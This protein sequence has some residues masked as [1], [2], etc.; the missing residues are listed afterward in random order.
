MSK[1]YK[2][3]IIGGGL[4][5]C[6][7][8]YSL[9]KRGINNIALIDEN[10]INQQDLVGIR[11]IIYPRLEADWN[12]ITKFYFSALE[13]FMQFMKS[14]A[15]LSV[16]HDFCGLVQFPTLKRN[17]F[18]KLIKILNQS[19]Q[20]IKLIAGEQIGFANDNLLLFPNLGWVSP[21]DLCKAYLSNSSAD[22]YEDEK[23]IDIRKEKNGLWSLI[24]ENSNFYAETIIIANSYKA[25]TFDLTKHF[26]LELNRGQTTILDTENLELQLSPH[27]L[28]GQGLYIIPQHNGKIEIGATFTRNDLNKNLSLDSHLDNLKR[29]SH[30]CPFDINK[31]NLANLQGRVHFRCISKD[32]MPIIGELTPSVYMSIA[33]GSR[34]ILSTLLAAEIIACQILKTN[35]PVGD[36]VSRSVSSL[37]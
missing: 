10:K 17:N 12:N 6:A 26:K 9:S 28:C 36:K 30:L 37:R 25:N 31:I 15:A 11:G 34:G 18:V 33:H 14:S 21:I 5:G 1:Y 23:I 2:I 4:A 35:L 7:A 8:A 29:L 20:F 16:T 22:L 24:S 13:S 32:R 19:E 27:I 3:A